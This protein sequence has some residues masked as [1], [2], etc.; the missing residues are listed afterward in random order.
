MKDKDVPK[1]IKDKVEE[2]KGELE[3]GL[4]VAKRGD[5]RVVIEIKADDKDKKPGYYNPKESSAS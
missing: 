1:P 3:P 2:K 4:Y 5:T